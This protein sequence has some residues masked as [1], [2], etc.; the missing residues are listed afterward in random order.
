MHLTV[1]PP[2]TQ[3]ITGI[4]STLILPD[5]LM[6]LSR[7]THRLMPQVHPDRNPERRADATLATARVNQAMDVR[8]RGLE[9]PFVV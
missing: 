5:P 2:A 4:R 8:S 6:P 9:E 7:C 3:C 1:L